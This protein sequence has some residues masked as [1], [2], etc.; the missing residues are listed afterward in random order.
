[1]SFSPDIIKGATAQEKFQI[2]LI[3]EI[4]KIMNRIL[5]VVQNNLMRAQ[6]DIVKQAN[7]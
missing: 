4:I 5:S 6:S 1:M 7:Y 2:H 3:T